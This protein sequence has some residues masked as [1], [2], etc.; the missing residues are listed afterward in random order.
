MKLGKHFF[1]KLLVEEKKILFLNSQP[2]FFFSCK[3]FWDLHSTCVGQ[4]E[5]TLTLI[6]SHLYE[7][8]LKPKFNP[9]ICQNLNSKTL[10]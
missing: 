2:L 8:P 9:Q 1:T 5:P 3:Y 10:I 6:P 7:R 4:G